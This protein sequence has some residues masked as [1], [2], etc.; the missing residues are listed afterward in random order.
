MFAQ[1]KNSRYLINAETIIEGL[2]GA[3][4]SPES[5]SLDILWMLLEADQI[6]VLMLSEEWE[7]LRNHIHKRIK[8]PRRAEAI[9]SK[10]RRSIKP[11]QDDK[12]QK[13]KLLCFT[14]I[15]KAEGRE[16]VLVEDIIIQHS[17]TTYSATSVTVQSLVFLLTA[18]LAKEALGV[19]I[20]QVDTVF[21]DLKKFLDNELQKD[22]FFDLWHSGNLNEPV[23]KKDHFH[24]PLIRPEYS[25]EGDS[26]SSISIIDHGFLPAGMSHLW[27]F[28]ASLPEPENFHFFNSRSEHVVRQTNVVYIFDQ[29]NQDSSLRHR[30]FTGI[31][32]FLRIESSV[33]DIAIEK[34]SYSSRTNGKT[35]SDNLDVSKTIDAETILTP[36][37]IGFG[38]IPASNFVEPVGVE[39]TPVPDSLRTP[40]TSIPPSAPTVPTSSGKPGAPSALPDNHREAIAYWV[41][42]DTP[43]GSIEILSGD[44]DS[45][46]TVDWINFCTY[47]AA[48]DLV[49][50]F[51]DIDGDGTIDR[52]SWWIDENL[53]DPM[54]GLDDAIFDMAVSG[55][56][57]EAAFE[58]VE[59]Y[60]GVKFPE[61]LLTSPNYVIVNDNISE[62]FLRHD[63]IDF[64]RPIDDVLDFL[65]SVDFFSL[66]P[67]IL[68]SRSNAYLVELSE[69]FEA[70]KLEIDSALRLQQLGTHG[71]FSSL[72]LSIELQALSIESLST[73]IAQEEATSYQIGEARSISM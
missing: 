45:D 63:S 11:I 62:Q 56:F 31:D 2:E 13:I 40:S 22:K 48:G 26:L 5:A 72:P 29:E 12:D 47:D 28:I 65:T 35:S 57:I 10:I 7:S 46:G 38:E 52:I 8:E 53:V 64:S 1:Q 14:N 32:S 69:P 51:S 27:K 39:E 25:L 6:E 68:G 36:L 17:S 42:V 54:L 66:V 71:N 9:L 3:A 16:V 58:E 33:Q 30:K 19:E 61:K 73:E 23:K 59:A 60:F 15:F 37:S 20:S 55:E 50:Q 67:V 24:G 4:D 41:Y 34:L 21:D 70:A 18:L 49:G 44:T 43:S